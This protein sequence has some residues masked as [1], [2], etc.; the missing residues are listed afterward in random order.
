MSEIKYLYS[1]ITLFAFFLILLF[2]GAVLFTVVLYPALHEPMYIFLSALCINCVYGSVGFFPSLFVNL[3]QQVPTV[4]YIGCLTQI[5]CVHTYALWELTLLGLMAYD[6]YA[7]ICNPLRYNNIM[8]LPTVFKM[9]C[10]AWILTIVPFAIHF[11]LT[12]RL[13][14]CSSVIEKIYCDNYS[15]VSLS[16]V[17]TTINN[18]YGLFITVTWIT[19]M[20]LLVLFSYV[21]ILRVCMKSSK[22]FRAKAFHT[23]I[24][25]VITM[26]NYVVVL[27]FEI[28]LHR[29]KAENLPNWLK[30]LMSVQGFVVTPLLNPLIYGLKLKGIR[31]K[32]FKLLAA[33]NE[34]AQSLEIWTFG[35]RM[36]KR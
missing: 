23:C 6:R 2:N 35:S 29:F 28:L 14:L 17:S 11:W 3:L 27:L 20:P 4:S 34:V 1:L 26:M 15:V 5:F 25:H 22:D 30:I 16:C 19:T 31:Q 36:W 32:L 33:K 21:Q 8:S 10:T 7:C 24:P 9:I 13:T 18:I 12:I